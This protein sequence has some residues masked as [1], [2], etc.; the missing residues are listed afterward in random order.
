MTR[1]HGPTRPAVFH[2]L[3]ALAGQ[4]LHGL[5]IAKAVD[6]GTAGAVTLG[7]GTL[8]RSLKEMAAEGLIEAVAAPPGGEDPR[9]RF[10]RITDLGREVVRDEATRLAH[11]VNLA[12]QSRVLPEST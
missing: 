1:A 12:R 6:E 7:P 10:Y 2:I 11:V 4:E 9:R 8:Y 3:L 5:G